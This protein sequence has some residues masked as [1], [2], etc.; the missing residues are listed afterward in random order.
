M[1]SKRQTQPADPH[2]DVVIVGAGLSGVGAACYLQR[3]CPEKSFAILEARGSMGGTW[4]LFR[5][6]GVRSDSDMETLG[7]S[8]RPWTSNK[9][10]SDGSTIL[11]YIRETAAEFDIEQHIRYHHKLQHAAWNSEAAQWRL[12]A[13]LENGERTLLTCNF[14]Y[15]CSGYYDYDAGYTP[16]W[17]NM[18]AFT[19]RLIHPQAWPQDLSVAGKR[20]VIIGSGA[21]AVTLVPELAKEAAHV[22]M[23]QR[24]PSY[25]ATKPAEDAL[26][27]RLHRLLPA[28]LAHRV[29]RWKNLLYGMYI[30]T[31]S[32]WKPALVKTSLV[33]L[34]KEELGPDYPEVEVEENFTPRYNPWDQRLCLAPDGDFFETIKSGRASVVTDSIDA[35]TQNGLRLASGETLGADIVVSATGLQLKMIG[36]VTLSVDGA[37]VDVPSCLSYKGAMYSGVPN[38]ASA[39]GYTNASWTLKCE[40]ISKYVC[41]LLIYMDEYGYASC[42]PRRPDPTLEE[43]KERPAVDLTSGYIQRSAHL[44]PKQGDAKPWRIHQNYFQDLAAFEYSGF[45]DGALEFK[46]AHR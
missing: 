34:V 18:D 1:N 31:M 7:F 36:G 17:P 2:F 16:T 8:F 25:I 5:Y 45:E 15:M 42:T 46:R 12:E 26:A 21:T 30:Y 14:L 32:R 24:S 44:L 35:F 11:N 40:L 33:K 29:V 9:S 6:P 4:D 3:R 43:M 22:T 19:G 28:R 23:L 37:P 13:T 27:Q 41:R 20:V 39:L 38:F 10:I